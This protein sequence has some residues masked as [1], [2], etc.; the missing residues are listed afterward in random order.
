MDERV[1]LPTDD[2][3]HYHSPY[4][5]ERSLLRE[6]QSLPPAVWVLFAGTFVNR[7]GT[8]V[9][10]FLILYLTRQGYSISASG[11]AIGF[12]GA[13]HILAS[14]LGGHLA[15][16]IGRRNTIAL[17]MFASAAA[18]MALSQ[19]H[20][21]TA[22]LV[23][24]FLAGVSA[25]M[26]RP[27][28]HAL[29]GDLVAVDQRVT[30]FAMYR[31]AVNLGFAAGPATAGFLADHSFFYLF[32][33]DAFS[34]AA[35]GCIALLALPHGLRTYT[36]GERLGEAVRVAMR[37]RRFVLFLIAST[38]VAVVDFQMGA[39]VALHVRAA[40]FSSSTYGLLISL[41]G[42]L[43]VLFE[44]AIIAVIRSRPP[45][46]LIAAG[47]L[48]T[49]AGFAL[50]GIAYTIPALVATVVIWTLGEMISSPLTSSYVS[51]LAPEQYRGRYMG[52]WVLT[53]S[54][55]L[56]IGPPLGTL[57]LSHDPV[58][59]WTSCAVLGIIAAAIMVLQKDAP[60][61]QA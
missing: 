33:G 23:V 21:Y 22:I 53:W 7:F 20:A 15:D 26:Y 25:E 19:V 54:V 18:M 44:L 36:R 59:L 51:A 48:L 57:L 41:N 30:A 50:T 16:R 55:G 29:I 11:V 38:C 1:A 28:S 32:A 24:T 31:F 35:Y 52:L 45:R 46:P 47:F 14:A 42:M 61:A 5:S 17:S 49:G 9:I 56:M 27:A 34:S 58:I 6:L 3:L 37:D 60:E 10:P 39:T 4:V 2:C 43:I 40:G 13:G 12:Y 8:F